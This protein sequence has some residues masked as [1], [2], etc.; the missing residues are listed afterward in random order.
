MRTGQG[1]PGLQVPKLRGS[2]AQLGPLNA[3]QIGR[4]TL[5]RGWNGILTTWAQ[6]MKSEEKASLQR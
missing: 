3:L 5:S 4:N 6:K 2:V 1:D